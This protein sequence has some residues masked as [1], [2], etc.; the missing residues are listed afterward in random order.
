MSEVQKYIDDN[1]ERFRAE[2]FDFL[3]I[4]SV[5]ARREHDA[6]TRRAADWLAARMKDAGLDVRIETT[7]GQPV[8]VG[9]WRGAGADAPT[10]L[11]YGH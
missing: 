6:D 11:I 1:L 4:P 9:E 10:V 7:P 2:L 3:R 8:V 5:S